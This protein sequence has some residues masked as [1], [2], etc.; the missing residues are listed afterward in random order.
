MSL[1]GNQAL[2]LGIAVTTATVLIGYAVYRKSHS[3]KASGGSSPKSAGSSSSK[4]VDAPSSS[5][6]PPGKSSSDDAETSKTPLVSNRRD[7]PERD[8]DKAVH[9]KIEELDK[10]GKKLFKEKK[11]RLW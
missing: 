9:A 7:A 4:S 2:F 6:T 11:V 1:Q 3:N 10:A 8:T 5:K